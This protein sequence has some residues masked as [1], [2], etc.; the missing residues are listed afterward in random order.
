[1]IQVA[2][3][4]ILYEKM[5]DIVGKGLYR[6]FPPKN[7][8]IIPNHPYTH[9]VTHTVKDNA[10]TIGWS[11][12]YGTIVFTG[13]PDYDYHFTF[14]GDITKHIKTPDG[15]IMR[16]LEVREDHN[17]FCYIHKEDVRLVE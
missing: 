10:G 5:L 4:H 1:M 14:V 15:W 13:N 12:L 6:N 9:M 17:F 16:H 8:R 2:I 11:D 3:K 7:L